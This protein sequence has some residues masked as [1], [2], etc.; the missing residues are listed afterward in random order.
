MANPLAAGDLVVLP[1]VP[2]VASVVSVASADVVVK[3]CDNNS[4]E[5]TATYNYK[6]LFQVTSLADA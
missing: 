5:H 1:G 3:W 2:H 6:S 4:K